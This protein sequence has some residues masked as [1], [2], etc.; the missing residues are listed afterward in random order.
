MTVN[1]LPA[2]V[3]VAVRPLVDVFAAALNVSVPGPVP[4]P[5][6]KLTKLLGADVHEH[7]ACVFTV[8]VPPPPV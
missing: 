6:V 3:A 4:D 5:L 7:P 2:T 1:A 8:I